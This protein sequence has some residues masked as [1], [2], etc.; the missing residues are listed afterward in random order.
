MR[1]VGR[2]PVQGL[3]F[4]QRAREQICRLDLQLPTALFGGSGVCSNLVELHWCSR[5]APV[6]SV[7]PA[8]E[9]QDE[10][11]LLLTLQMFRLLGR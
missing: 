11:K 2:S 3:V 10:A 5:E 8:P 1:C 7:C 9:C 4:L 6:G